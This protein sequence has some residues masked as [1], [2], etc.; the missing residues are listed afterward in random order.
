MAKDITGLMPDS[1]DT[2]AGT[3]LRDAIAR[4]L[5]AIHLLAGSITK[6][7]TGGFPPK[8]PGVSGPKMSGPAAGQPG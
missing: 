7:T 5:T 1:N 2:Q 6:P 4:K 3:K 8:R